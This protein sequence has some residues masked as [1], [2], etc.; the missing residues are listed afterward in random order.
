LVVETS[1]LLGFFP[2]IERRDLARENSS[3][4]SDILFGFLL[5]RQRKFYSRSSSQS[6]FPSERDT[7]NIFI[8]LQKK[9][10]KQTNWDDLFFH[11]LKISKPKSIGKKNVK[12]NVNKKKNTGMSKLVCESRITG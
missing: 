4:Q 5:Q 10:N 8:L 3:E 2:F 1:L 12:E 7:V 11:K 9:T 6:R